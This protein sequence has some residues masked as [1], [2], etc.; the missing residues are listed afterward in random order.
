MHKFTE[1]NDKLLGGAFDKIAED[2]GCLLDGTFYFQLDSQIV[3]E[4][5]LSTS[6]VFDQHDGYLVRVVHKANGELSRHHFKFS[7][8]FEPHPSPNC[9]W[10]LNST[11]KT[12]WEIMPDIKSLNL[13]RKRI[14]DY[15]KKF[16]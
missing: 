16:K 1:M 12:K 11:W 10:D 7:S 9:Y 5:Y 14:L 2:E 3:V 6:G 15:L 13:Y 4:A 8:Y